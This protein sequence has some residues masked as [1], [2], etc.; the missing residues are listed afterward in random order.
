M[1]ATIYTIVEHSKGT[2]GYEEIQL[3]GSYKNEKSAQRKLREFV[4]YLCNQDNLIIID[5][6][7]YSPY[8]TQME[9]VLQVPS[10]GALRHFAV[11]YNK[12]Y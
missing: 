12:L 3:W 11:I 6:S 10:T 8:V 5:D 7:K 2:G 9:I 1:A 4:D